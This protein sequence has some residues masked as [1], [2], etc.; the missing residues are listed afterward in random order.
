[1]LGS[2][3]SAVGMGGYQRHQESTVFTAAQWAELE[4][5]TLIYKYLMARVPVPGDLLLPLRSHSAA[6]AI[7]SFA[8][9]AAAPFYHHHHHPSLSYNAY[10]GKKLD[11]EP[12]RCRCTDGK[13]WRCS[14]EAHPDSKY[15]ER[16]MHRGR[17]R[18][19]KPVESRT[20]AP[21]AQ[22]QPQRSTV[23]TAT[24]DAEEPC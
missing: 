4:Q 17:N 7:Y 5:Q 12:W 20:A 2:S 13:K 14:K 8:N 3:P 1:M 6:A 16:H 11:L 15:C 18:S 10:Y 21:A 19:R 23:T 24:H 22:S 9:P